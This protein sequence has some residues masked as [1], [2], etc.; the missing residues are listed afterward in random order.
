M[1][2]TELKIYNK[3]ILTK[4]EEYLFYENDIKEFLEYCSGYFKYKSVEDCLF[5]KYY[6]P[7]Q[8]CNVFTIRDNKIIDL[9]FTELCIVDILCY[10]EKL[11][12]YIFYVEPTDLLNRINESFSKRIRDIDIYL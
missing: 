9:G 2:L 10:I 5:I 1:I 4:N 3:I 7:L 12:N 11:D 6:N 8:I